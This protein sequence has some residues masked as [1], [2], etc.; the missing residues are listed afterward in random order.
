MNLFFYSPKYFLSIFV[1]IFIT[2]TFSVFTAIIL[3]IFLND[4]GIILAFMLYGVS[5][6]ADSISTVLVPDY[7]KHET[8]QLFHLL[9]KYIPTP[10]TLITIGVVSILIQYFIF[11][12]WN[13]LILSYILTVATFCTAT[14]NIYHRKNLLKYN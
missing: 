9:E 7:K 10:I 4:Y 3:K 11:L 1:T 8:N 14:A 6:A 2:I 13:D 5:F 12:M